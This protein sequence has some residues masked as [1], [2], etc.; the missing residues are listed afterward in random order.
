[1]TALSG[2]LIHAVS[3]DQTTYNEIIATSSVIHQGGFAAL[4]AAGYLVPLSDASGIIPLG[5]VEAFGD[6]AANAGGAIP[7]SVTGNAAASRPPRAI[8][9]LDSWFAN[10]VPV[11]GVAGTIADVGDYVYLASDNWATDLT[12]T[13]TTNYGPVGVIMRFHSATSYTVRM[14]SYAERLALGKVVS[15]YLLGTLSHRVLESVASANVLNVASPFRGRVLETHWR[16]NG[17]HAGIATGTPTLSFN[18]GGSA[19]SGGVLTVSGGNLNA[20]ADLDAYRDGTAVTNTGGAADVDYDEVIRLV[21]GG[22]VALTALTSANIAIE[23]Y[24]DVEEK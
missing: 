5:L 7:T 23:V 12:R 10:Q 22:G 16:P 18:I 15:T 9:R 24:V 11:A 13:P 21:R 14:F 3:D 8:V 17:F 4:N 20:V 19:L 6:G 2:H 1:M